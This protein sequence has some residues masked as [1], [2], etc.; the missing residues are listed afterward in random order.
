MSLR[1]LVT[2]RILKLF[3]LY[4]LVGQ[5]EYN[6]D[7]QVLMRSSRTSNKHKK[8]E[9]PYKRQPSLKVL[10]KHRNNRIQLILN[11]FSFL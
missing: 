2:N 1:I 3:Y 7:F 4:W 9:L 8:A 10:H 5:L 6:G 11:F